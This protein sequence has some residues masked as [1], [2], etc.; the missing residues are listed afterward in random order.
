MTI[1]IV[2][3]ILLI[4]TFGY[5]WYDMCVYVWYDMYWYVYVR[6]DGCRL[7]SSLLFF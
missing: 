6:Q 3:Q 5:V 1:P 4:S 2:K 7:L